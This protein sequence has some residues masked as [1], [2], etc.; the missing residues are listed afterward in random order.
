MIVEVRLSLPKFSEHKP[1]GI[2]GFPEQT[3]SLSRKPHPDDQGY[4]ALAPF[5]TAP[6]QSMCAVTEGANAKNTSLGW[7]AVKPT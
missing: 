5:V 1:R 7:E 6:P 2:D 4:L 3:Q